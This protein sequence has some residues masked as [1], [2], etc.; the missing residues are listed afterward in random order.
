MSQRELLTDVIRTLRKPGI[1]F[2]LSG[3]HASSL[4]GEARATHDIDLVTKLTLQDVEPLFSAFQDDRFYLSKSAMIDAIQARGMFNLLETS[5]GENV[6][7]WVLTDSPFD[8]SRFQRR[9][10]ID[11]GEEIVEVSS[12]E[13]T[14]LM[15]LLWCKLSGGSEKQIHDVL[16]IYELQWDL[17]DLSYL[18]KW[19][20][21]LDLKNLWQRIQD[22]SEPYI[23]PE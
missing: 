19:V 20:T 23:R 1:E 15:K 10:P 8:Q 16:M 12:P 9:Q 21:E 14:I 13:D 7:F 3:S 22:D 11:I 5:M 6:D 4:Q 2:M 17:L 18:Q